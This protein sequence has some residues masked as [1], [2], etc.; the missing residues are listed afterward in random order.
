MGEKKKNK[1]LLLLQRISIKEWQKHTWSKPA[2]AERWKHSEKP[3]NQKMVLQT[4]AGK[5]QPTE[6]F[7]CS[8]EGTLLGGS[9]QEG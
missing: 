2:K 9:H 4:L 8:S 1:S 7:F 5:Q 6:L 3:N